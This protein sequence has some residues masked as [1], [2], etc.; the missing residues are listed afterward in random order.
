MPLFIILVYL[1]V[2]LFIFSLYERRRHPQEKA[3]NSYDNEKTNDIHFGND[4]YDNAAPEIKALGSVISNIMR[5]D[6]GTNKKELE[7]VRKFAYEMYSDRDA[8]ILTHISPLS[9]SANKMNLKKACSQVNRFFPEYLDRYAICELLFTIVA[10]DEVITG[11]EWSVLLRTIPYLNINACDIDY[12]KCKYA[13][14][15]QGIN[16]NRQHSQH[17]NSQSSQSTSKDVAIKAEDL[18]QYFAILGLDKTATM[19]EVHSAYRKLAKKY[20]PDTTVNPALQSILTEKFKEI[21]NA[22]NHLKVC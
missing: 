11:N 17:Y 19:D 21:S 2:F 18:T 20:H 8:S 7:V 9:A 10:A 14:L 12:F 22:Y 15:V 5:A 6:N 16:H 1:I 3:D 13:H 4:T